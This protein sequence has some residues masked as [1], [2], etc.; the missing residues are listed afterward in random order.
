M[1]ERH[2]DHDDA[3]QQV[4]RI[5][6]RRAN[7]RHGFPTFSIDNRLLSGNT[8][9]HA[10]V[11]R[12]GQELSEP[13][14]HAATWPCNYKSL[15]PTPGD[16]TVMMIRLGFNAALG[17]TSADE[18]RRTLNGRHAM[19]KLLCLIPALLVTTAAIP[20]L[21]GDDAKAEKLLIVS[22]EGGLDKSAIYSMN[23]DGTGRTKIKTP[24][25]LALDPALSPDGKRLAFTLADQ[26]TSKADIHVANADGSEAQKVTENEAKQIAFAPNWSPDGKRIAYSVM[27]MPEGRPPENGTIIVVD[28]DG[29]NPKKIGTG[30]LPSWSPDGKRI[31]HT[32]LNKA[33]DFDPH[34]HVMDADGQNDKELLKGRSLMGVYSPD[35]KRIVYMGAKDGKNEQPHIYMCNADGSEPKELTPGEDVFEVAPRWSADGKRIYFNRMNRQ[36]APRKIPIFVMDVDGKNAKRVSK[37]D[38]ADI[39]GGSPLLLLT[40]PQKPPA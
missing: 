20:P 17:P 14:L 8:Y 31:L 15:A 21:H 12:R 23:A 29:K 3:A 7:S 4:D 39:L 10:L 18:P 34:L 32:V 11:L 24:E 33:D 27:T 22:F 25:G 1:I 6:A 9:S 30:L 5:Q 37:E 28:A 40:R 16:D 13:T 36:D 2:Q 35:S 38:A 26:K 19:T